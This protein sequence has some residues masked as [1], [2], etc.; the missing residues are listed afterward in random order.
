MYYFPLQSKAYSKTPGCSHYHKFEYNFIVG[1]D[2]NKDH[3]KSIHD[4]TVILIGK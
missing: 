1:T 4:D 2:S 3:M